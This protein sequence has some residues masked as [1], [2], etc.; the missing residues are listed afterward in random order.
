MKLTFSEG[1]TYS[2]GSFEYL[3]PTPTSIADLPIKSSTDAGYRYS[4]ADGPK[5]A[6]TVIELTTTQDLPAVE[7]KMR[8]YLTSAGFVETKP[9]DFKKEHT[10]VVVEYTPLG[11]HGV[12]IELTNLDYVNY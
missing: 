9:G 4:S 5:P 8:E 2:A 1:L 11:V 6:I 7:A 3:L 12:K 10:E